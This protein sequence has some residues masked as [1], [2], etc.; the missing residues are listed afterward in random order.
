VAALNRF[1]SRSSER[2]KPFYDLLRK[3][4]TFSWSEEH[5][6]AFQ[7]LKKYLSSAP[8]LAKPDPGE[9]LSLYLS[10]TEHTISAVLA[11]DL[12]GQQHP[13]YYVSKSLLDA[14]VRYP[15]LEKFVLAL[16]MSATKLRPY[17]ECH[18]IC[19]RTNLPIKQVLRKPELSGRMSK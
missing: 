6:A 3:N 14:E 4:K 9:T 18:P 10:V 16:V 5:E 13:V 2:C 1:I 11:K 17:F 19:V 15:L 12:D 7:D 8:L